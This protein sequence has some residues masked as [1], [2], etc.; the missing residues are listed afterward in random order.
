MKPLPRLL[1]Y[2]SRYK[3]RAALALLAMA[4]VA[5]ATV[6][7]LFQLQQV[8]DDVLGAGAAKGLTGLAPRGTE[9]AAPRHLRT[10]AAP[11]TKASTT[12][13]S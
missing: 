4:V 3:G 1:A 2:F 11:R 9:K 7:L 6:A 13:G 5:A 8:I 12:T 10:L